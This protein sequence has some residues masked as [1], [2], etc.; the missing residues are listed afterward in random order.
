MRSS[1]LAQLFDNAATLL[2]LLDGADHRV[3]IA[4]ARYRAVIGE[5]RLP[6]NAALLKQVLQTGATVTER[7]AWVTVHTPA[8]TGAGEAAPPHCIDFIYQPVR[9][10][11]G[12][13]TGVFVE[14]TEVGEREQAEVRLRESQT[15]F[16]AALSAGQMG[17]WETDHRSKTRLWT[18]EGMALFGIDLPGGRG[19]VDGPDDEFAAALHPDDRHLV[20]RFR[21]LAAE[22]DSFPAEYRIV[23]PDGSVQWLSG[24]GLVVERG[25]AGQAVRLVSIMADATARKAAEEQLRTERE[26]LDLALNAGQMGA[27]D[28][29][30]GADR[31]W[32]SRQTYDLFGLNPARFVP[33]PSAVLER[34]HPDDRAHFLGARA[35]A[36]ARGEPLAIEF[37]TV[38]PDGRTAWLAHRGQMDYDAHGRAV[39]SFGVSMDVTE[40]KLAE[41]SLRESEARLRALADNMPQMAW[42][43]DA[44]GRIE[45]VNQRW[46]D[47]TGMDLAALQEGGLQAL[48]HPDHFAT[49][50]AK[51]QRQVERGED[52]EDTFPMRGRDGSYRWF[53]SRMK[54][55]DSAE[56]GTL[57]FFGTNTDVTEARESA[58]QLRALTERL[59]DADRRKDE[60]LATLAHELRNPLAPVRN[61]LELMKRAANDV[62]A[63]Q[64]LR[65]TIER[66]IGQMVRL[67]DDLLDVGRITSNKLELQREPVELGAILRQAIETSLPVVSAAGHVLKFEPAAAPIALHA[68][69]VRLNQV[70]TNLIVNAAKFTPR[71]GTL[72]VRMEPR[73]GQAVVSVVDGGIGMPVDMLERVFEPFVQ[74]DTSI[75][76]VRG[77][78]GLGLSLVKR[79]VEM[80]GGSASAHSDGPGFGSRF[81]V[82]L[83]GASTQAQAP[84]PAAPSDPATVPLPPS[85]IL[86][87]DDN[88]DGAESLAL[89]LGLEGHATHTAHDG[90][91]ALTAAAQLQPDVVL[92]DIGMPKMSGHDACV[93]MRR[94]AWGRRALILAT[95]GWGQADDRRRSHEAGFDAH[96]VKPIDPAELM[97]TLTRLRIARG[98]AGRPD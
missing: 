47:Y 24:R 87:A 78:L 51:F 61:S 69:P 75:E 54:V 23:R 14:G 89:L 82:T 19:T 92:L 67:I 58:E 97:R 76:R 98:D 84:A 94:E 46:I 36:E 8:D 95:T 55:I 56:D 2:A 45:W 15:H 90:L 29:D 57:R 1:R 44:N 77:G 16:K 30:V 79:L 25:A 27:Y 5:H 6:G 53:L 72:E 64:P 73:D 13:V 42:M 62:Q 91:Q 83:P 22:L 34:L 88:R 43:A 93:A 65:V 12:R 31:L 7:C 20:Q 71:P 74:V 60:F 28:Y 48:H 59:S 70:F 9:D 32:W 41:Q 33:T 86:I 18:E 68:D 85:V 37:R 52:W 17:S 40:R 3:E 35:D 63:M 81:E 96:L 39:R 50:L 4:N 38:R 66:Q 26:R 10:E 49:T 21:L 11:Q 80:H